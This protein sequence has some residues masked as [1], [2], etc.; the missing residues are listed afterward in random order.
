MQLLTL[1][2]LALYMVVMPLLF[3]SW[4]SLYLNEPG[5]NASQ[6]QTSRIVIMLATLLWP[7]VLP[8]SYLELLNKVKRYK[9]QSITVQSSFVADLH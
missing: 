7:V 9:R 5:M 3:S 6:R 2:L 1:S 8:M 4:Y